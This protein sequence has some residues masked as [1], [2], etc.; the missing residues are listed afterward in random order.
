MG[1]TLVAHETIKYIKMMRRTMKHQPN[2]FNAPR[3]TESIEV[4]PP[5][6]NGQLIPLILVIVG[7]AL[8]ARPT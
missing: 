6:P 4:E 3:L 2:P 8:I 5:N 1:G 7:V